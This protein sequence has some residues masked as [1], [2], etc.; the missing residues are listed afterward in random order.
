MRGEL[1]RRAVPV[2]DPPAPWAANG[3]A[4]EPPRSRAPRP[5]GELMAGPFHDLDGP[6][7][8][9]SRS[10]RPRTAPAP[11]GPAAPPPARSARSFGAWSAAAR[12]V[13]SS[14]RTPSI[15]AA[16][17]PRTSRPFAGRPPR[18]PPRF[19][20]AFRG[21]H[22]VGADVRGE[23]GGAARPHR[24]RRP[25]RAQQGRVLLGRL[26]VQ[27]HARRNRPAR[28]VPRRTPQT[29]GPGGH[30]ERGG[31]HRGTPGL[32]GGRTQRV[33]VARAGGRR[34]GAAA[35][36][37]AAQPSQP[38]VPA[39]IAVEVPFPPW[40]STL[41]RGVAR[42]AHAGRDRRVRVRLLHT[43]NWHLGKRLYG[44]DRRVRRGRRWRRRRESRPT[45]GFD[46]VL[47]AG[48]LLDRRLVDSAALGDGPGRA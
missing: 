10:W 37:G 18:P 22:A 3:P 4:D 9:S 11:R 21:G 23:G 27:G 36:A 29:P 8:G 34:G 24:V 1:L 20:A 38:S 25:G 26:A 44:A 13:A 35:D 19:R 7:R 12:C 40:A 6:S 28:A 42:R 30:A 32:R 31:P 14:G 43:G 33:R 45:R 17:R 41:G 5:A 2:L 48:D 16:T 47:V 15:P 39:P 46:A